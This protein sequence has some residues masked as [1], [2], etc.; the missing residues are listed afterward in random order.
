MAKERPPRPPGLCP[1]MALQDLF[2]V[3]EISAI[4]WRGAGGFEAFEDRLVQEFK[5]LSLGFHHH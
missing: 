3:S 4:F 2:R 5:T 1:T